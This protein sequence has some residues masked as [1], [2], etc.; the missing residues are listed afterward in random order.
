MYDDMVYV[1]YAL[2]YCFPYDYNCCR[3]NKLWGMTNISF[4]RLISL[5]VPEHDVKHKQVR[6]TYLVAAVCV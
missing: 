1:C 2:V 6:E 5:R 3:I 4:A